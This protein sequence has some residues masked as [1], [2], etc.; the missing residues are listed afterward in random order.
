M[1]SMLQKI[2]KSMHDNDKIIVRE[3]GTEELHIYANLWIIE[4]EGRTVKR[5]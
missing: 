5:L 1:G 3:W 2:G 4:G